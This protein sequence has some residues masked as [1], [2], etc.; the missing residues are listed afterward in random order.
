MTSKAREYDFPT[1][2][3]ELAG[4]V[5]TSMPYYVVQRTMEALNAQGK[6]IVGAKILL[7]GVAYKK[8]VDDQRE[9]PSF[10]LMELLS[11]KGAAV[12]YNDPHIPQ[13]GPTRNYSYEQQSIDLTAETLSSVRLRPPRHRPLC[14]RL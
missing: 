3:I 7:L 9:S 10:K 12:S 2:F 11:K 13:L 8:D 5:N 14:L 6:S 1:K 4:E